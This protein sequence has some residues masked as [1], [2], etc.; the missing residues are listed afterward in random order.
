MANLVLYS[1]KKLIPDYYKIFSGVYNDFRLRSKTEYKFELEPLLYEDFIE[2]VDAGLLECYILLEDNIPTGFLA[3]TT[4]ISEAL[5]LNIIHCL[6]D[7]NLNQKRKILLEKFLE[8]NKQLTESKVVTYPMLGSQE[9]FVPNISHFGFKLVGLAVVRFFM[10]DEVC[11]KILKTVCKSKPSSD[12]KII[13]WDN[14]YF[15]EAVKLINNSF[16]D[17]ADAL[18]DPRFKTKSGTEDILT[19]ITSGFYGDFMP[20]ATKLAINDGKLC[21]ICFVNVTGGSI[22]NVPLI[23]ISKRHRNKGLGEFLLQAAVKHLFDSVKKQNSIITEINASVETD[24]FS[25]VR[26]YRHVGFKEDYSYPQAFLP[27]LN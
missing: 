6:G 21:G 2:S 27:C 24:N 7:E 10:N 25:A 19:K 20:E 23:G 4:L 22:A 14:K 17:A 9:D 5:E 15:S 18:F 16:K 26:M 12:Y 11:T 1:A 3:Y 8:D 13:N